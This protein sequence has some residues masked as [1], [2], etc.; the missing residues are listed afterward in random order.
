LSGVVTTPA[1]RAR[2]LVAV[3][4]A[5]CPSTAR[6]VC[7]R[8]AQPEAAGPSWEDAV[9][10]TEREEITERRDEPEVTERAEAKPA[11][12]DGKE[13]SVDPRSVTVARIVAIPSILAIAVGPF[14][15]VTLAYALGGIPGFVYLP[16]FLGGLV[17]VA[18]ALSFAFQWPAVHHR[19]L[20]YRV[21]EAGVRIR[22]GVF[23]RQVISIPTSRVQHTDVSQGPFQR[24]FGL[25][26]LTVHTAGTVG[27]SISLEGLEHGV[28]RR[29]RD[30]LL[31][32]HA[33]GGPTDQE[34]HRQAGGQDQAP[35]DHPGQES[36]DPESSNV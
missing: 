4:T 12:S 28:A 1:A 23:W 9:N 2:L 30:H 21:D 32:D 7:V 31:P 16:L 34:D 8:N 18:L 11:I 25:A 22:R 10:E 24:Q 19:H 5:P 14:F 35:P 3:A 13:H 27:A 36:E 29:L 33:L 6:R 20:S 15:G 26:T 17:L